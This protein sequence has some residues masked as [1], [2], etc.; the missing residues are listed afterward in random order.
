MEI[1]TKVGKHIKQWFLLGLLLL[2]SI[3][4]DAQQR[5]KVGVVLSGGGAK[6]VAHVGALKVIE[7]AGIPIDIVV[8]T[9]MGAIVGGLYS[10]GYT[11]HQLD[12]MIRVQDWSFL[13]TDKTKRKQ[14]T[15]LEK[16]ETDKYIITLPFNK[17]PRKLGIPDGFVKGQNLNDLFTDLTM[18]YHDSLDFHKLPTPFACVAVDMRGGKEVVFHSGKLS[19]AMRASMAIP[20]AFTPVRQ[21]SMVLVDGGLLNNYPVDVALSMGAEII[22]GVDVQAAEED[23]TNIANIVDLI[24]R[25]SDITGME[26]Y[27]ENVKKTDVYI[28]VDVKGY[29]AAS[30]TPAALDTLIIRGNVAAMGA[31][32]ELKSVKQKIGIPDSFVPPPHGPYLSFD[33]QDSIYIRSVSFTGIK[34]YNKAKLLEKCKLQEGNKVPPTQL[35]KAVDALYALQ[36]YTNIHYNLR[37]SEEGYDL[38]FTMEEIPQSG[39][40]LGVRI[41]NEEVASVH[42]GIGYQFNTRIPTK[43]VITGRLGKRSSARFDYIIYPTLL[44]NINLSYMFEYNDINFYK[45][46]NREY[47]TTFGHH[48][49]EVGYT[50][51]LSRNLAVGFGLRY[52]YYNYDDFLYSD[53]ENT[54]NVEPEGFLNYYAHVGYETMNRKSYPTKG[55]SLS[56]DFC[57]HTDNL[58]GYNGGSP[59]ASASLWW[60]KAFSPTRRFSI[61]PSAYGRILF[62]DNVAY[63]Y[64]NAIGG[65]SPGR[66]LPQQLPFTGIDYIEVISNSVLVGQLQLRQRLGRRNYLSLT[67]N[68]ALTGDDL[69]G[70]F[71]GKKLFGIGFG[72]GYDSFAGPVDLSVSYSNH[73]KD[74]GVYLNIGY[75]F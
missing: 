6:G 33:A 13:L 51:I 73:T 49:G 52:E 30:F 63:P 35:K 38:E 50:R 64:L 71:D 31:R 17:R 54:I 75:Q 74:A 16:V 58:T 56:A 70:I 7:E 3:P 32:Q 68:Y 23:K 45:K 11:P 48:M 72:Y 41:D 53:M 65:N 62:G 27:E 1:S 24:N 37:K 8:G 26:K 2:I 34:S 19:E 29:T 20:A 42:L 4:T 47:N 12:S 10:I 14:K 39:F 61:L 18:G 21:D 22:I 67:G 43:G 69:K 59:F 40:S 46:G 36:T 9:S 60:K 28:K 44:Q 25:I 66:Y 5:K 57:L 55:T 15:Y